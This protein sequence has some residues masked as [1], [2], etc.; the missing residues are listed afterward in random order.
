MKMSNN[1]NL[2]CAAGLNMLRKGSSRRG[3]PL[4]EAKVA[5]DFAYA[6]TAGAT[7]LE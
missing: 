1:R 2:N 5:D 6:S 7:F 3:R 4:N